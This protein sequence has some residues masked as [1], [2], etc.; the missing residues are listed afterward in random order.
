MLQ[1]LF[2]AAHP[3][4]RQ[5]H[6]FRYA[7]ALFLLGG[8][9]AGFALAA[10]G[11][12]LL[13]GLFTLRMLA[14]TADQYSAQLYFDFTKPLALATAHLQS[15]VA[16]IPDQQ[17]SDA[18]QSSGRLPLCLLAEQVGRMQGKAAQL[19]ARVLP[20]GRRFDAW[21]ELQVPDNSEHTNG[22]VFQVSIAQLCA[23]IPAASL[24]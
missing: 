5:S 16:L 2:K 18:Q 24:S 19:S 10:L 22:D 12:C 23:G 11:F 3:P 1:E 21:L 6:V 9:A 14:P 20:A 13:F 4:A 7:K 15:G 17:V 8:S